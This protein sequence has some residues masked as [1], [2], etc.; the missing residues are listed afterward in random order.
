MSIRF[1]HTADIHLGKPFGNY[2]SADRLRVARQRVIASLI[3]VA[4]ANDAPHILIA[5]D[6]FETPNPSAQTWRQALAEMSEAADLSW[7]ILPGNHDNLREGAATWEGIVQLRHP[8]IRVLRD[9][10][11]VEIQPG[12][13]LLPAPLLSRRQTSDPTIGLDAM[14]TPQGAIRIG[15]AHGSIQGFSEGSLPADIIAPDRDAR[16]QLDWLALGDWH[17]LTYVSPR[18]AYPGAPERTGFQHNGRGICL[19]VEVA[20]PGVVPVAE[21]VAVGEFNWQV[22]PLDL[23][24]GDDP[25]AMVVDALPDGPRRD[26]LVKVVAQGRLTLSAASV[27]AGLEASIGPEFCHFEVDMEALGT[28]VEE[29]DL[30]AISPGGALRTA[31][32]DLAAQSLSETLS[33][34]DRKIAGA[35]LRRLHSL[36]TEDAP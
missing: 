23:M 22:V 6:L 34:D 18:V 3:G 29:A 14:Q 2:A 30:E 26:M 27:L 7:W 25:K 33:E 4:R 24:P 15:L 32:D 16:A 21:E 17:G 19:V 12:A 13:Y 10:D 8:N 36:M 5:G 11:P 31:S 28:E 35:A 1:L 20:A 9:P